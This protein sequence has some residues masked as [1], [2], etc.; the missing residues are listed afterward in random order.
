M[1]NEVRMLRCAVSQFDRANM[2]GWRVPA[3]IRNQAAYLHLYYTAKEMDIPIGSEFDQAEAYA[4]DAKE[5]AGAAM[6]SGEGFC[7]YAEAVY[8]T[9]KLVMKNTPGQVDP[10][11]EGLIDSMLKLKESAIEEFEEPNFIVATLNDVVAYIALTSVVERRHFGSDPRYD[12][13][14]DITGPALG[15]LTTPFA[16]ESFSKGV[17]LISG[18][19]FDHMVGK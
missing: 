5:G 4:R 9:S 13:S 16:A 6:F 17:Y 7:K 3:S 19:I 8:L 1:N 11:I 2:F 14:R 15:K 12:E 18:L 10:S